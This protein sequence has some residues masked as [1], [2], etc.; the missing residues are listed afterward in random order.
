MHLSDGSGSS[1]IFILVSVLRIRSI[2]FFK[3][4]KDFLFFT[5]MIPKSGLILDIGANIGV[6]TYFLAKRNLGCELRSFEPIPDNFNNLKRIVSRFKLK[7]TLLHNCG[8]GD[9]TGQLSMIMPVIHG[10]KRH[11]LCHVE[12]GTNPTEEGVRF[13]VPI[14]RLDDIA[15]LEHRMDIKAIKID[16]E[17]FEYPVFMGG[18]D[19]IRRCRPV[20]F[21]EL[22]DSENK[23][24]VLNFFRG[25]DYHYQDIR[26]RVAQRS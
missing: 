22:W 18:M 16:V 14:H 24:K 10:V 15:E 25:M 9:K 4:Q 2:E 1:V 11:A 21:C 20:I 7:K 19:L 8:L 17:N 3:Y 26:A 5:G 23:A 6:T 12:D 13:T